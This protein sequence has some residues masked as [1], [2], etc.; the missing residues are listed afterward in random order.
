MVWGETEAD[1]VR[2]SDRDIFLGTLSAHG[3][4]AGN[5]I[6]QRELGWDEVKY[7]KIHRQL[8]EAGVIEKGKGYG[9][10]VILTQQDLNILCTEGGDS[11]SD[12]PTNSSMIESAPTAIAAA[13]VEEYTSEIQLYPHVKKQL[14]AHWTLRRQLDICHCEIMAL[15]GR[16][17]TGGS[18]S[19]PDLSIVAYRKYEFL[20]ERV[21]EFFSFEVKSSTDV[22]IKGVMEALAH[23]EAATRSYVIYYTAGQDFSEFPEAERIEELAARHGVGVYAAKD[24]T[25]FNQWA[26]IVTGVGASPDP[27]AVDTFIRRTLSEE[28][29]TKVRKWV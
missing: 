10:S 22:S 12:L 23:R 17:E 18:W 4:R 1:M 19:R 26:E 6:L 13:L 3:N 21:F 5:T 29:K 28:A 24:V 27:E 14:E 7:W 8:F 2:R 9:G 25:D 16:R 15:Q 11:P 20:P